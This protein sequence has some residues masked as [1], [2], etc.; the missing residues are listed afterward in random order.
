[1]PNRRALLAAAS[2]AVAVCMACA[3]GS[4]AG[5]PPPPPG[6]PRTVETATVGPVAPANRPQPQIGSF[7]FDVEGMDR[8]VAPG[9]NFFQ[10][11]NG[12]W[13]RKAEIPPDRSNYGMFTMLQELSEQRTR[14]VIEDAAQAGAPTGSEAQKVGDYFASFMDEAAIES[15]GVAPLQPRLAR[16]AAIK[17]PAELAR[18]LGE[19]NLLGTNPPVGAFV[20]QDLKDPNQYAAYVGQ[21]GLGMPDR[22]YYLSEEPKL[23]EVR[24][25]YQ[26]HIAN[27]LRLGGA[28]HF[29]D[30]S[31]GD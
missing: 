16:I 27:L 12:A 6:Q 22:D 3:T 17:T 31:Q 30:Q 8:S 1:M 4:G 11:A 15:K 9:E 20:D 24:R 25:K 5:T 18:A 26:S 14:K 23:V 7:G 19:S 28:L 29:Q 2:F 21:A 13:L 10:F